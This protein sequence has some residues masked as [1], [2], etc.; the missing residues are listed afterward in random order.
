MDL[1][2][3]FELFCMLKTSFIV[4]TNIKKAIESLT[5]QTI[6]FEASYY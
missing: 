1:L 6:D 5:N 2:D 4:S 3:S